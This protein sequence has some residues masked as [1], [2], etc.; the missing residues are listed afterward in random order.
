MRTGRWTAEEHASKWNVG[1]NMSSAPFDRRL[2]PSEE[3]L[4][5]VSAHWVSWIQV[6]SPTLVIHGEDDIMVPIAFGK[7]LAASIHGA[8]LISIP[9]AGHVLPPSVYSYKVLD[10]LARHPLSNDNVP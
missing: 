2:R 6:R 8:E 3:I 7:E 5:I 10:F 1:P 4:L 9:R